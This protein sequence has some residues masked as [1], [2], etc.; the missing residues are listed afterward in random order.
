VLQEL[1]VADLGVVQDATLELAPGLNVLTGETGAGKTMIT[2]ALA[3]ALGA[4]AASGLVRPGR[5][6]L[7]VE[8]LFVLGAD[9]VDRGEDGLGG[10]LQDAPDG[11]GAG[12]GSEGDGSGP[13]S[14]AGDGGE[15]PA[16]D[17]SRELVLAR[18]VTIDG[19]S[20][21]RINGR[22]APVAAL[23][24]V[25]SRLVEIHG[26]NQAQRLLSA[27]AQAE[28]LDRYAG[29]G[30]LAVLERYRATHRAL[31]R[32]RDALAAL[33]SRRRDREREKDLLQYQIREIEGAAVE[34]GELASLAEETSRL[35]HADRIRALTAGIEGAL[36]DEGGASDGLRQAAAG[37]QAVS[38][39][40]PGAAALAE[41]LA[42]AVA[43][44][45]DLLGEVR[46]YGES[47][48]LDPERL[49]WA[50][51]RIRALRGLERKY[52]DGE[53]GIL[54]YLEDARARLSSLEGSEAERADLEAEVSRLAERHAAL[55]S[56]VGA[57]RTGAAPRLAAALTA[58]IR[59][60]GMPAGEVGVDL[61]PLPEP[62]PGGAERPELSFSA[63]PGQPALPLAKAASGGELSRLMLACRSVLADLDRVPTLVFDEVDSGLGGRTAASVAARLERLATHRQVL[64]V[65]HLAQIA[66]NADRH[67]LVTKE[68]GTAEVRVL[69]GE[70][71]VEE[72]ARMLSGSTGD[73]SLAHARELISAGRAVR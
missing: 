73:V 30:H 51:E 72:L 43:E 32:A 33:D 55:A 7:A 18:S 53:E 29:P 47:V 62:G 25:G 46:A 34:P 64:V 59:E 17:G 16:E 3:L 38:A 24:G 50:Q 68:D 49:E 63:G 2:V 14:H 12:R 39:L 61:V 44:A 22:M 69:E 35:A 21:T 31:G 10:W 1:H 52:G 66:A 56:E 37:A 23:A 41:R 36:G 13:A 4:R 20:S 19:R 45:E 26:Q 15:D 9:E 8:A 11:E 40:D 70:D 67:F 60:L 5:R 58:E 42:A 54:G 57:G 6:A 27:A 65:T 48:E 71:R 28:F